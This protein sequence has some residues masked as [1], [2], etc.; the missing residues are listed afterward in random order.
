MEELLTQLGLVFFLFLVLAAAVEVILEAFQGL[1]SRLGIPLWEGRV[2]LEDA[3]KLSD[4]FAPDHKDLNTKLEGIRSAANQIADK[5]QGKL[6][7]LD[8]I[9]SRL[10]DST[11]G[12][13]GALAG[14]LNAIAAEIKKELDANK[15]QRVFILRI[16][17]AVIGCLLVLSSEF[18]VFQILANSSEGESMLSSMGRLQ[19]DWVNVLIGGF[20]AAAGSSFWHDQIDRVRNFKVVSKEMKKLAG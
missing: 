6:Q 15:K 13:Q 12:E 2:S 8:E 19:D 18:Y 11:G 4:E 16:L 10:V 5:A 14:E 1:L 7:S 20:A 17:A 9:K 3:L